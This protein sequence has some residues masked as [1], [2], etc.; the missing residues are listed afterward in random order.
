[1]FRFLAK[2]YDVYRVFW[3]YSNRAEADKKVNR[4]LSYQSSGYNQSWQLYNASMDSTQRHQP[5]STSWN[6]FHKL[7]T[8]MMIQYSLEI[9]SNFSA[10]MVGKKLMIFVSLDINEMRR[11]ERLEAGARSINRCNTSSDLW[12][13]NS[14]ISGKTI[15]REIFLILTLGTLSALQTPSDKSLSLISQAKMLGHSLL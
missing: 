5:T 2:I 8:M 12:A 11:S 3:C 9:S 4:G 13:G 1:M 7:N 10:L 14:I 6:S 15:N